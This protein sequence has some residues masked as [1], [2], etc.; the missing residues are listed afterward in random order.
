MAKKKTAKK[1]TTK[2]KKDSKIPQTPEMGAIEIDL[3]DESH[4]L[5]KG[6]KK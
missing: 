3:V 2:E 1:K 4:L 5:K 6:K